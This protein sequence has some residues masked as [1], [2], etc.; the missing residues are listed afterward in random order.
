MKR[1]IL[2]AFLTI[3]LQSWSQDASVSGTVT[4]SVAAPLEFINVV[5]FSAADSSMIKAVATDNKGFYQ[6]D[7]LNPGGY[8]L[9]YVFIGLTET[10]SERFILASGEQKEMKTTTMRPL[11]NQ[12]GEVEVVFKKPLVQVMADKTVFNV[13]GTINSTGLNAM[14]LL[15]KAPGVMV[16]NNDNISVKG[17]SGIIVYIDGKLTPLDATALA[18]ML[19]NM[20]SSNIESIEIITNP[21][22]KYDAAGSAGII[23]IKLKKNRNFGT[24]GSV[25]AGYA[26]Q[27]YSKYNASLNLNHRNAKWNVFGNYGFNTGKN[28]NWMDFERTQRNYSDS[29]LYSYDQETDNIS[30]SDGHS[31]KAGVDR[32]INDRNT[33]GV[34]VS[35]MVSDNTFEGVSKTNI[36]SE[37]ENYVSSRLIAGTNSVNERDNVNANIN[38]HFLDTLGRD[39]NLDAD[40]G[41]YRIR[42]NSYQPNTY[43]YPNQNIPDSAVN[44]RFIT[45][46]DIS[47]MSFK[48]D[49]EQNLFKGKLGT[50]FKTSFVQ[51][52]NTLDRYNEIAGVDVLDST[53]SN[54][55]DYTENINALYVNFKRQLPK[56]GY[57]LGL[58]AEQT[59]SEGKLE[60]FVELSEEANRNVSRSYLNFFPSGGITYNVNDTNQFSLTFSRRIDRPSYQD[61]NPFEFKLDELSYQKG[62]P[63]LQPQYGHVLEFIYTYMYALNASVVYS[64]NKDFFTNVTDTAGNNASYIQERNLGYEEWLGLNISSPVPMGKRVS[65]FLNLNAGRKHIR[66]DFN[67]IDL[68]IWSYS[69]FAQ[70]TI[71]LPKSTSIEL[72][73]WFSGPSIWGATFVNKPMGSMDVALRKDFWNGNASLRAALGD[74]FYTSVWR[75]TSS[76]PQ[77]Q[78]T[79]SGGWESRV[80]RISL[81]YNFGNQQ[82]KMLQ[83]K[84]GS[85][86]LKDRVK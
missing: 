11:T 22:A 44:Y 16:D 27:L 60:S 80:F 3:A 84:S 82:I 78:M 79:G 28:W 45:P 39:L 71:S 26:V 77:L 68:V 42:T 64:Y 20:Q 29:L 69:A 76:I 50:G 57:Q 74:V 43:D 48:G 73:G 55:F 47:I 6:I 67:E 15:R 35:G 14:E 52:N 21:S 62:N 17:R 65:G 25:Q 61:L 83:R 70:M 24:N 63:F 37:T 51:T 72:S 10:E 59:V 38:Y 40:Y 30:L 2:L 12:T 5:A 34:M 1:I 81:S 19:K 75:S 46:I 86:D 18:A 66:A 36:S 56:V 49:Y 13:E 53:L 7:N 32:F 58:R 8:F 9:K 85:D 4:D 23:N 33:I 54:R 31:F 41:V